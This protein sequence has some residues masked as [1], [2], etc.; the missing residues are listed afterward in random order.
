MRASKA[1]SIVKTSGSAKY[2]VGGESGPKSRGGLE[3]TVGADSGLPCAA[4]ASVSRGNVRAAP[5][6][7][8]MVVSKWRLEISVVMCPLSLE[9][10]QHLTAIALHRAGGFDAATELTCQ[11]RVSRRQETPLCAS[12]NSVSLE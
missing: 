1:G 4:C 5:V 8:P 6:T 2:V 9:S 3:M 11:R 12:R 7:A 10:G